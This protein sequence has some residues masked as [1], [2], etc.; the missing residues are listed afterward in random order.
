MALQL[1]VNHPHS[2]TQWSAAYWRPTELYFND[3]A[4]TGYIKIYI[5][6][7]LA[8]R[9]ALKSHH[10]VSIQL[11]SSELTGSQGECTQLA[12]SDIWG[13]TKAQI[14]TKIKTVNILFEG[15]VYDMSNAQD[16]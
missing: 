12:F 14:Y 1:A 16:V 9:T 4:D 3:L 7:N 6:E 13:K 5:Y 8:A 2:T 11:G 10:D 15:T